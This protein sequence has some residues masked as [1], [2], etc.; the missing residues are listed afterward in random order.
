MLRRFAPLLCLFALAAQARADGGI[1]VG[2]TPCNTTVRTFLAIP[3]GACDVVRWELSLGLDAKNDAPGPGVAQVEYGLYGKKLHKQKREFRWENG[4]GTASRKDARV[5]ELKRGKAALT[6]WKID[7]ETLYVLDSKKR[8][9][10]GDANFSYALSFAVIEK[11]KAAAEPSTDPAQQFAPLAT[12]AKVFGVYEGR[13]PCD[14]S[15]TL[16]IDAPTDCGKVRWRL[17]LFQDTKSRALTTYRLESALLESTREGAVSQLD[18]TPFDPLAKVLK[19]EVSDSREPVYLLRA[20]DGVLLFLDSAGK[21]GLG[22]RDF[23][24]VLNRRRT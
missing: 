15:Q 14:I 20:D 6:L 19:L 9:L 11:L 1:F 21:L 5:V 10:V 24:Y 8:P 22:N 2:S 12:G 4:V 13:T 17:T 7:D 3:A 23:N 18:G 16:K